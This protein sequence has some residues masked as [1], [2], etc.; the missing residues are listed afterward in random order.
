MY[1]VFRKEVLEQKVNA[2]LSS[3]N[4][5]RKL[6]YQVK[7]FHFQNIEDISY[8]ESIVFIKMG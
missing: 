4:F 6:K 7:I 3:L 2:I 8:S 1:L 5:T